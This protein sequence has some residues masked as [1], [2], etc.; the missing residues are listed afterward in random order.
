MSSTFLDRDEI[1]GLTGRCHVKMQIA[2]LQKMG[3]PFFVN[4]IGRP[5]VTRSA[6][7]G[8]VSTASTP[9]KKTWVPRVLKAG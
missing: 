8:R 1:K 5:V 6:I 2:A 9:P 7:E 4:D 3:I